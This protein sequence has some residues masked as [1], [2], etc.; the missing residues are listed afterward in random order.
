MPKY[1]TEFTEKE[2]RFIEEYLVDLLPHRAAIAAGY[3]CTTKSAYVLGYRLLHRDKIKK[4]ID[5]RIEARSKKTG[6]TQERVIQE[7]A[8]IAFS[9]IKNIFDP[10]TGNLRPVDKMDSDSTAA[11]AGITIDENKFGGTKIFSTTKK[12]RMYDKI[13]ALE[14]LGQHLGMFKEKTEG[15]EEI[16]KALKELAKDLPD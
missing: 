7:L 3:R 13:R 9:D 1:K 14:R 6:I 2:L 10:Q 5:R 16:V 11:I 15:A 4:E 8:K 12:I